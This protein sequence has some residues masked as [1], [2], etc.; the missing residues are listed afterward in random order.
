MSHRFEVKYRC[1]QGSCIVNCREGVIAMDEELFNGLKAQS[2]NKDIFKSPKGYCR[3]GFTQPFKIIRISEIIDEAVEAPDEGG[4]PIAILMAEHKK[5]L[6]KFEEI[7]EHVRKRDMDALWV[8]TAELEND[9]MLH[10]GLKEEEVLFPAMRHV[11]PHSETFVAII[12]EEHR[13]VTTLLHNFRYALEEDNILD[14]IIRSVMVSL[15]SHI[16][17][18]DQEFF[19][20][21]NR[22][23][24]NTLRKTIVDGMKKIEAA[25]KAP[26]IGKRTRRVNDIRKR[27]DDDVM[28]IRENASVGS[29]CDH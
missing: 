28:A 15:T 2:G 14:G 10:S 6:K 19:D 12:R 27:F 5:I 24:D 25:H 8:S 21:V 11:M 9:I 4:D 26:E 20:I 3:L 23:L 1:M 29:C 17:K 22:C 13:E 16:R 7:E 18:E